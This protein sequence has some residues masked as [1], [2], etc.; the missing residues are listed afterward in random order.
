MSSGRA[1]QGDTGLSIE[2][3]RGGVSVHVGRDDLV[4]GVVEDSGK[5]TGGGLL[6]GLLDLVVGGSLLE[7]D[8]QVNDGDVLG[9]DTHGHSGELSVKLRDDLS[10][11]LGGSG[12]GGDDVGGGGTSSSP[13]L[14]GRSVNGLLG[15]GVGVDSGHESLNDSE[16]VVDDLG[17]RSQAVGGARSVGENVDVLGVL[18]EVDSANEH[19]GIGRGSRAMCRSV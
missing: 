5:G 6:D 7:A 9:G 1:Y 12:G 11:G 13:V 19:G 8:G 15:G 14:G 2:D 18:V 16:L 10:D 3:G 4:L 17:E